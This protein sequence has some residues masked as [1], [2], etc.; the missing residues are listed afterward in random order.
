MPIAWF[1]GFDVYTDNVDSV[2]VNSL[3][4]IKTQFSKYYPEISNI[5]S[6][7]IVKQIAEKVHNSTFDKKAMLFSGGVDAYTTYLRHFDETPD[8][9]TIKGADIKSDDDKQ[10][11][12]IISYNLNQPLL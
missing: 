10:W 3:K 6:N 1:V 4:E 5:N 2:F 9:I 11:E 12:M 7:L 8:L